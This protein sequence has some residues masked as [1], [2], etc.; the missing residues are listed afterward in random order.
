MH[1][2]CLSR[3]FH[4]GGFLRYQRAVSS[5]TKQPEVARRIRA[6]MAYG[7][8]SRAE[9]ARIFSVNPT[10]LDRYTSGRT[11]Y[12]PAAELLWELADQCDLPREFF[13]ADLERLAELVPDD[14]PRWT[15]SQRARARAQRAAQRLAG[16][17]PASQPSRRARD[18]TGEDA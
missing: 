15:P 14:A 4:E 2:K 9:V 7:R 10:H 1:D 5:P 18:A 11:D 13:Y 16:S 8:L 3:S 12:V 17:L 6:A